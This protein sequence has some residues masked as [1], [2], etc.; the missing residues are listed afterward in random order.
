ML[1]CIKSTL[2]IQSYTMQTTLGII[3]NIALSTI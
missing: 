2:D 1:Y 3:E